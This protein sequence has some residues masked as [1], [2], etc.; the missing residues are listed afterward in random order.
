MVS[1]WNQA[2]VHG[3]RR[4]YKNFTLQYVHYSMCR[5]MHNFLKW[6]IAC[7][8]LLC[9]CAVYEF[10]FHLTTACCISLHPYVSAVVMHMPATITKMMAENTHSKIWSRF[11]TSCRCIMVCILY[12]HRPV[13]PY[14]SQ[15]MATLCAS[16]V[17]TLMPCTST[18][19]YLVY[20]FGR[21][22]G[23][24]EGLARDYVTTCMCAWFHHKYHTLW[25]HGILWL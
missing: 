11:L 21:I 1:Q 7:D 24:H 20:T 6:C 3:E 18:Y 13:H 5:G 25:F 17:D 2:D 10:S 8:T 22:R 4:G 23:T 15:S 14:M 12:C 16:Q 19:S 9:H